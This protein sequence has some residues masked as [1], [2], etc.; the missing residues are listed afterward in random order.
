[1]LLQ[2]TELHHGFHRSPA[3]E[4]HLES[5]VRALW[6]LGPHQPAMVSTNPAGSA[7]P[8]PEP[9]LVPKALRGH[10]AGQRRSCSRGPEPC[11]AGPGSP[12]EG[13]GAA[14]GAPSGTAGGGGSSPARASR[15]VAPGRAGEG[16]SGTDLAP[17]GARPGW[18][19]LPGAGRGPRPARARSPR[20]SRRCQQTRRH[21][22]RPRRK[23]CE[24]FPG[25]TGPPGTLGQRVPG[26][27]GDFSDVTGP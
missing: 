18:S 23:R 12:G 27:D 10:L 8:E 26:G 22:L 9:S 21:F 13:S 2:L 20:R 15:P 14:P 19:R 3:Q 16:G 6:A 11:P 24:P 7:G 5:L 1:M 25:N 17:W 4:E